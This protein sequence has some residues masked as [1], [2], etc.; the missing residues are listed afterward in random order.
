MA[1]CAWVIARKCMGAWVCLQAHAHGLGFIYFY[2]LKG[3]TSCHLLL[4]FKKKNSQETCQ[5]RR[6]VA[7][8]LRFFFIKKIN[9]KSFQPQNTLITP[10]KHS[11]TNSSTQNTQ[12]G[13]KNW[14]QTSLDS[15]RFKSIFSDNIEALKKY[16]QAFLISWNSWI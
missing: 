12:K 3:W 13:S 5:G 2:F 6:H 1:Q 8:K 15:P 11:K 7:C 14:N 10:L 16:H 4:F 9:F